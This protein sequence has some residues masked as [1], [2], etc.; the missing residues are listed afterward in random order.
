MASIN[1]NKVNN[2]GLWDPNILISMGINPKNG[3]PYAFSSPCALKGDIKK[4]LRVIDQQDAIRRYKWNNLP[5]DITQELLESILYYKGQGV[6]F[7]IPTLDKYYFLPYTLCG[8]IDVYGRFTKITPLP[9]RGSDGEK[10]QKPWIEGLQRVPIYKITDDF[11]ADPNSQCVLLSDYCKQISQ[12]TISRQIMNDSLLD[13]MSECIPYMRT[14]LSNSTGVSGMR[15][16]S[17]DEYSQVK[18]ASRNV[19]DAALTG[20]KWIP[21]QGSIDFQSLTDGPIGKPEDFLMAMQSLDNYRLSLYGLDN[22]GLFQKASHML[23]SEEATNSH[24][25]RR[26]YQDG[27][28]LRQDFCEI[29][30]KIFGLEISCEETEEAQEALLEESAYEEEQAE[31]NTQ[32]VSEDA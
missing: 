13:A 22:G 29:A 14:A 19:T 31:D 8:A 30:N 28:T 18:E 6:L 32:E 7:Y 27:L 25:A 15:V 4:Q 23:Q 10:K 16:N 21:I 1:G 26:A 2:A 5:S 20:Q 11:E 17:T 9:Y 24:K 3:L 12:T